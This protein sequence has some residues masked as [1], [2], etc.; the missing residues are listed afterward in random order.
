MIKIIKA[1]ILPAA[2]L[3]FLLFPTVS[4]HAISIG[5]SPASQDVAAGG[6]FQVDIV[7][8]DLGGEIVSA[9]DLDVTYDPSILSATGVSFS[10]LLNGGDPFLSFQDSDISTPGLVDLAE[11]SLLSDSELGAIQP[12]SF[13]LATLSFDAS[14]PGASSLNFI[15]NS[16]NDVKGANA[17]VLQLDIGAGN[18]TVAASVPEPGTSLLFG[19]G[20]LGLALGRRFLSKKH[21]TA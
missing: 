15:F 17:Q 9:F 10:D 11:L 20:L 6:S 3:S 4:S 19:V 1:M 13:T 8:S 16:F 2:F 18:V 7:I 12:D 21:L 5:F 14:S